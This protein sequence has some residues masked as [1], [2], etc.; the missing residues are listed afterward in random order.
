MCVPILNLTTEGLGKKK[1]RKRQ[2]VSGWYNPHPRSLRTSFT[3]T[4]TVEDVQ[5]RVYNGKVTFEGQV[6]IKFSVKKGEQPTRV[7][8]KK[9]EEVP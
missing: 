5:N 8:E 7:R 3:V 1:D 9:K 4:G 2:R 6:G